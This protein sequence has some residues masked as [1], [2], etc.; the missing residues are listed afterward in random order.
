ML[1]ESLSRTEAGAGPD[2]VLLGDAGAA[3]AAEAAD[4]AAEGAA[5]PT[6][7]VGAMPLGILD[8]PFWA[9]A[10][11]RLSLGWGA[12]GEAGAVG[13]LAE[14]VE[15]LAGE[16]IPEARSTLIWSPQSKVFAFTWQLRYCPA[17]SS[18]TG[19]CQAE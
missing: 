8:V 17:R 13:A 14:T 19:T 10:A 6:G 11:E 2:A 4:G 5:G 9:G 16:L 1:G 12:T 18:G 15:G 3:E 7:F